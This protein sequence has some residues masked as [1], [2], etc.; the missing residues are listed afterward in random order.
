MLLLCVL[1]HWHV[2]S[3]N[4]SPKD[5]TICNGVTNAQWAMVR[6]LHKLVSLA[7]RFGSN[8]LIMNAALGQASKTFK[9]S[10]GLN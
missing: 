5:T 6:D 2:I 4:V 9:S 7:S 8:D 10:V 1:S 3:V